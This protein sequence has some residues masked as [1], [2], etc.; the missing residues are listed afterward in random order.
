M[1]A[2]LRKQAVETMILD[3]EIVAFD[4]EGRPSFNAMQ[5]RSPQTERAVLY[6]FDLLH[7]AGVNLRQAPYTDRRRYLAQSLLPSPLVQ[8]V[9]SQDDGVALQAAAD[10]SGLEGVVGKRKNSRY[11]AGKRSASWLKV[12]SITSADFVIGGYT[13]G[14][15]ARSP[16]GA[17]L[18]GYWDGGKLVY[19]SHVGS[20]FNDESLSRCARA[21]RTAAKENQSVLDQTGAERADDMGRAGA[22]R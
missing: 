12:K 2:E 9:H 13:Q 22:C 11:E 16:L 17:L 4:A 5:N 7:F 3:A 20:G 15:G 10:A 21:T 19:A 6:C 8:L 14:K 1:C 18:V